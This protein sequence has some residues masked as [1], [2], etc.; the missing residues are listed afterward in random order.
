MALFPTAPTAGTRA[1]LIRAGFAHFLRAAR[2]HPD[3]DAEQ[4]AANRWAG[5]GSTAAILKAAVA[6]MFSGDA[7][8]ISQT[9]VADFLGH[10]P[11]SAA[12]RLMA[13]AINLPL[14]QNASVTI[15]FDAT[16]PTAPAPWVGEG[17]PIPVAQGITELVTI[18]PAR[19][20]A[21]I[22]VAS[23]SLAKQAAAERVFGHLLR[24]RAAAAFDAA[25]FSTDAAAADR[26]AGLLNGVTALDAGPLG[27]LTEALAA[28]AGALGTAG[29]SGRVVIAANPSIAALIQLQHPALVWPVLPTQ[30]LA[31]GHVIA[32]DPSG[33]VFGT[34]ADVDIEASLDATIHMSD[35]PLELVSGI[36]PTTADP[37]R[38]I[39]QTDSI[40][41]RMTMDLAFAARPGAVQ[42]A[43]GVVA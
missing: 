34:G 15:P 32:I 6:P 16:D 19:R 21:M 12:S 17:A 24:A 40:A 7:A 28:L 38:D 27:S 37:I 3:F 42:Y 25:L 35:T 9:A 31:A 8:A 4:I 43:A 5:D 18:G 36:G 29:G 14:G 2:V 22:L 33:L 23:R 13:E 11:A 30:A 39:Y 1:H 41:L 26:P 20:L 10:L